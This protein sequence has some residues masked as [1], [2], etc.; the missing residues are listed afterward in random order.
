MNNSSVGAIIIAL[1][2]GAI[3]GYFFSRP[4]LI[5]P[6]KNELAMVKTESTPPKTN[7]EKIAALK[8]AVR[9]C[10]V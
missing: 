7:D 6:T 8:D 5:S 10:D 9:R 2:V 1:I 3:G 4:A